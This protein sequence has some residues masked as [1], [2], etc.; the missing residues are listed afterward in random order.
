[1]KPPEGVTVMTDVFPVVAPGATV[2]AVPLMVKVG[3]TTVV[4]V[5]DAVPEALL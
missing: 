2:I 1:V 4:T 5:T 3:F